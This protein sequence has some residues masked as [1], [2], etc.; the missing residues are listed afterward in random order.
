MFVWN[1]RFVAHLGT[2]TSVLNDILERK[3]ERKKQEGANIRAFLFFSFLLSLRFTN[4]LLPL[5]SLLEPDGRSKWRISRDR[6]YQ[7][8]SNHAHES[9]ISSMGRV[10]LQV[11]HRII[12][13]LSCRT[14]DI[15]LS[16]L[17]TIK[18]SAEVYGKM[19]D[20]P[21]K[22][23]PLSGVSRIIGNALMM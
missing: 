3:K 8:K 10:H 13:Y 22:G 6:C 1:D 9:S 18:S 17:P 5:I 12:D 2:K 19:S 14:L 7:C 16:V 11:R 15:P 21:L 23:I 20:G 4:N